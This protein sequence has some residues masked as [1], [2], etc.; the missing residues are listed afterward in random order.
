MRFKEISCSKI[1]DF[2]PSASAIT[3]RHICVLKTAYTL[4]R[5]EAVCFSLMTRHCLLGNA[6]GLPLVGETRIRYEP[7]SGTK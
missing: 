6:W 2:T 4:G 3:I 5:A 1:D 7:R